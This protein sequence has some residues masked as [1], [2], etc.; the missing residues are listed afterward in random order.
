MS[1]P[2]SRTTQRDLPGGAAARLPTRRLQLTVGERP[3][4]PWACLQGSDEDGRLFKMAA[5]TRRSG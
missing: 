1:T 4:Q 5:A 2:G 3:T